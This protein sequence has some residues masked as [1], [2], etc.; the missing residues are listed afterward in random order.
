MDLLSVLIMLGLVCL[1]SI[2]VLEM[3]SDVL[4]VILYI[5]IAIAA[6]GGVGYFLYAAVFYPAYLVLSRFIS[7]HPGI[8]VAIVLVTLALVLLIIL[9]WIRSNRRQLLTTDYA[10]LIQQY[11]RDIASATE[12]LERAREAEENHRR[13]N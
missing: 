5:I 13:S 9:L 11:D 6:V 8:F 1:V 2:I 10:R 12:A 7:E 4:D 3:L